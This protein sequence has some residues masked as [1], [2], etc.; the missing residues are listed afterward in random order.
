ML[1]AANDVITYKNIPSLETS[2]M[3][4]LLQYLFRTGNKMLRIQIAEVACHH[5]H[6]HPNAFDVFLACT[7]PLA[8]R[9]AQR[10]AHTLFI[11]PS[12]WQLE[13]MYDGAVRAAIDLFQ[14]NS[15]VGPGTD[16]FRRYLLRALVCGTLRS[17]FMREENSGIRPVANLAMLASKGRFRNEVERDFIVR[18]LLD[19]VISFPHLREPLCATLRSIAALGPDRA[20]K[21]HAYTASGDPDR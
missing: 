4:D 5:D 7:I 16:C 8:E 2:Q 17:Y 19:R 10:R 12:D 20:L 11:Y 6:D 13:L 1:T 14:C 18:E 21:E 3:S 15:A 9:T